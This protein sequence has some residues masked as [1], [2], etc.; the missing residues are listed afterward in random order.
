M[1]DLFYI[2]SQDEEGGIYLCEIDKR[3]IIDVRAFY[4]LERTAW[5]CR[6]GKKL[7]ALLREPFMQQSGIVSFDV[8]GDGTISNRSEVQPSYGSIAS[9]LTVLDSGMYCTNY[10]SATTVHFP[11]TVLV[12]TGRGPDPDRQQCGHPHCV[13]QIPGSSDVVIP[14]LG[15]DRLFVCSKDLELRYTVSMPAGSGPRH[16]KFSQD[17][18]FAY[19][20]LEMAAEVAV[21]K[22]VNGTLTFLYSVKNIP[23][24]FT[25]PVSASALLLS[26]DGKRLFVSSRGY[27]GVTVYAVEGEKLTRLGLADCGE[28]AHIRDMNFV[29][30]W[31]LCG[32]EKAHRIMVFPKD[33]CIGRECCSV[34]DV[35][36]PWCILPV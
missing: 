27:R 34:F 25:D 33:D 29:G 13:T 4:P 12:H 5:L 6:Y 26:D 20:T 9:Y 7:Y 28:N 16:I 35:V 1:G 17:G 8:A 22:T 30:R 15:T 24:A 14:D 21:L 10:L 3:G 23:D 31:L 19:C 36:R 32:D 18:Q 2:A 11:D